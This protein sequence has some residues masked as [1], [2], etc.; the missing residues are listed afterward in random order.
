MYYWENTETNDDQ[1][2]ITY[3]VA[4]GKII[5]D[6]TRLPF[7]DKGPPASHFNRN[8][9]SCP[10]IP[11]RAPLLSGPQQP[12]LPHPSPYRP[13][14]E[15]QRHMPS[16]PQHREPSS[17]LRLDYQEDGP[18]LLPDPRQIHRVDGSQNIPG[19]R[20]SPDPRMEHYREP[21]HQD[22]RSYKRDEMSVSFH[23]RTGDN[24]IPNDPIPRSHSLSNPHSHSNP[25]PHSNPHSHSNY[26]V[27]NQSS[28]QSPTDTFNYT[29]PKTSSQ[30]S[31]NITSHWTAT[32]PTMTVKPSE[33][34]IDPRK[35]YSQFKIKPKSSVQEGKPPSD[36]LPKLLRDSSILDKPI[37]PNDLFGTSPGGISLFGSRNQLSNETGDNQEYGEIKMRRDSMQQEE[38]KSNHNNSNLDNDNDE[39]TPVLPSYLTHLNLGISHDEV[40]NT[41]DSAFGSLQSR[42]RRLSELQSSS[43]SNTNIDSNDRDPPTTSETSSNNNV[44]SFGSSLY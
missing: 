27:P 19:H 3:S 26:S 43:I 18:P 4:E 10:L 12:L 8:D 29:I 16:P 23:A 37:A 13:P 17:H 6:T 1:S 11:S 22:P 28:R 35:K 42:K 38:I 2:V 34:L 32:E 33:R 15:P 7:F 39:E 21:Y 24:T 36:P 41:I 9:V 14:F 20:V 5:S 44:F 30:D 31:S 25:Y 40:D